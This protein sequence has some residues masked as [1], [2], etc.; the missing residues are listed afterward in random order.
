MLILLYF[1]GGPCDGEVLIRSD[2]KPLHATKQL[3]WAFYQ[4]TQGEV[5]AVASVG[6]VQYRVESCDVADGR[7]TI[8]ARLVQP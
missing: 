3:P 8:V 2:I 5:G 6:G 1:H 4:A 7:M